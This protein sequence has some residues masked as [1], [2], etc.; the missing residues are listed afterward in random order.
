MLTGYHAIKG[1]LAVQVRT[2]DGEVFDLVLLTSRG[3]TSGATWRVNISAGGL[4]VLT[5]AKRRQDCPVPPMKFQG[6]DPDSAWCSSPR[7]SLPAQAA[8]R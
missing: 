8:A 4:P 3:S 6:P 7:R 2:A 1:A 5:P